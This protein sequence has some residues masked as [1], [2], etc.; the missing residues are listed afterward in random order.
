MRCEQCGGTGMLYILKCPSCNGKGYLDISN[1]KEGMTVSTHIG[2][3]CCDVIEFD[4]EL[5]LINSSTGDDVGKLENL[6]NE[7]EFIL[8]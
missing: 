4:N 1:I 5:W 6:F 7:I 3:L 8:D 2:G